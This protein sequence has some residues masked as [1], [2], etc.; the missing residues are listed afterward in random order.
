MQFSVIIC[1]LAAIQSPLI[2]CAEASQEDLLDRIAASPDPTSPIVNSSLNGYSSSHPILFYSPI[3][4]RTQ[5]LSKGS[6]SAS[7]HHSVQSAHEISGSS[8]YIVSERS[9]QEGDSTRISSNSIGMRIDETVTEG[10]VSIGA[11]QADLSSQDGTDL[12]SSRKKSN[13][14]RN[15]ALMIEEEYIGTFHISRNMTIKSNYIIQGEKYRWLGYDSVY[16]SFIPSK[17]VSIS[18]DEVFKCLKC[19]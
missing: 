8:E 13:P 4:S 7:L 18:A 15:P 2:D 14:W 19:S 16:L 17:P 12:E 10:K 11:F 9:Y 3:A 5:V 6:P 1:L